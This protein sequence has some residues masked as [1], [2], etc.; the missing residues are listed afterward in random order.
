VRFV[1]LD[2]RYANGANDDIPVRARIN[3][4]ECTRNIDLRGADRDIASIKMVYEE[5]SWG[6]RKTAT[7]RVFGR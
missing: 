4:G 5:T 2:V 6:P 3:R 7:V 1:D